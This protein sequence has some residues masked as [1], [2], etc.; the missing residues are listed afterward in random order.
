MVPSFSN[1]RHGK[2]YHFYRCLKH[3]KHMTEDCQL[4]NIS[5]GAIEGPVFDVIARLMINEFYIQLVAEDKKEAADYKSKGA[6]LAE[7]IRN[8]TSSERK[9][10]VNAFVRKIEVRRDGF[11]IVTKSEGYHK[12]IEMKGESK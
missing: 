4:K 2:K 5:A 9:R 11:T 3:H 8:M 6:S 7:M 10:L 12:I 1:N